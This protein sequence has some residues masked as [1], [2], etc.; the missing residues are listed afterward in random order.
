MTIS[1]KLRRIKAIPK[2]INEINRD[3][4]R[5]LAPRTGGFE[6]NGASHSTGGN[7]SE[8]T[9][10]DYADSGKEIDELER[11]LNQLVAEVVDEINAVLAGEEARDIDRREIVKSHLIDGS[12]LK[13]IANKVVHK[14]Y[15]DT[16]ALFREG[17]QRL[18]I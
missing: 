6:N 18:G 4:G 14:N 3:R 13:Y 10:L 8:R 1:E 16:K 11:E 7:S 15:T 17:C 2:R 12:S 9:M 5:L